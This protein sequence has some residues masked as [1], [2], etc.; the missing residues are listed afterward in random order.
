MSD[1]L[2]KIKELI[3]LLDEKKDFLLL[4]ALKSE[5]TKEKIIYLSKHEVTPKEIRKAYFG[6]KRTLRTY[7]NNEDPYI[8]KIVSI[9][10]KNDCNSCRYS[11]T[12]Y[13]DKN[14]VYYKTPSKSNNVCE[15]CITRC[16]LLQNVIDKREE[17]NER[18]IEEALKNNKDLVKYKAILNKIN[19]KIYKLKQKNYA[20]S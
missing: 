3:P 12:V 13:N 10:E 1:K 6:L 11:K 14:E 15:S 7:F 8:N 9:L 20:T 19:L 16:E 17:E 2:D 5:I 18:C 4:C